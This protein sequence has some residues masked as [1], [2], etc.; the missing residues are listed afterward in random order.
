MRAALAS[1][2]FITVLSSSCGD[3]GPA[4]QKCVESTECPDVSC[5][6]GITIQACTENLCETDPD[7][8]CDLATTAS[9]G[10]GQGG[11]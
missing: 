8:A 9:S 5:G 11:S 2:L 7:V 3:D 10:S 1:L 6:T 4:Q